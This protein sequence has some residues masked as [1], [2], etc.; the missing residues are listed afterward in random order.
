[1]GAEPSSGPP[2]Y[3][4][5]A[6]MRKAA[7]LGAIAGALGLGLVASSAVAAPVGGMARQIEPA[8]LVEKVHGRRHHHHFRTGFI[9]FRHHHHFRRHHHFRAGFIG[10]RRYHCHRR[11]HRRFCHWH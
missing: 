7:L 10:F 6:D 11:F 8:S 5:E 9:G 1:V 3:K 4:Q 2:H